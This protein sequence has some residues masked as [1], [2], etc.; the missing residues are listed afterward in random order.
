M[1]LTCKGALAA[2]FKVTLLKGAH[3]TYDSNGKQAELIERAVEEE[4]GAKGVDIVE[5]EKW[6][7]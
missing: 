2:G 6:Q 1:L 7:C 4:L 3:S 5:W